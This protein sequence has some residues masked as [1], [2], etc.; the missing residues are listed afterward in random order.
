[1]AITKVIKAIKYGLFTFSI[2]L[3]NTE[4][5]TTASKNTASAK[6]KSH[7]LLIDSDRLF[8]NSGHTFLR[9]INTTTNNRTIRISEATPQCKLRKL[10]MTEV[11]IPI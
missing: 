10:P 6:T 5:E 11:A 2:L 1:M 8:Q 3:G 9:K 4:D 7:Q